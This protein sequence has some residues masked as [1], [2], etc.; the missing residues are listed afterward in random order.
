M[1][2]AENGELQRVTVREMFAAFDREADELEAVRV[3]M[4]GAA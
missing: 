4:K 3:C 2:E 1:I